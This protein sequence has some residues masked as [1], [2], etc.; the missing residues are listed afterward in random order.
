[1]NNKLI[2]KLAVQSLVHANSEIDG[3][4][5]L[6]FSKEKFVELVVR[7]CSNLVFEYG[8][9]TDSS[10]GTLYDLSN[11]LERHFGVKYD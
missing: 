1:M 3:S 9:G 4:K 11:E 6:I 10:E 7:E 8:G 2:E 5:E